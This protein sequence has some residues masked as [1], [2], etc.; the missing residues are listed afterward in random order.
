M[1]YHF[2]DRVKNDFLLEAVLVRG[3]ELGLIQLLD[4][5]TGNFHPQGRGQPRD[6]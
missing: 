6:F 2:D 4:V 3:F 1:P 5:D